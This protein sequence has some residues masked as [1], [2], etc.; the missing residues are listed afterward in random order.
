MFATPEYAGELDSVQ[1]AARNHENCVHLYIY[2]N[3]CLVLAY[4]VAGWVR[5]RPTIADMA[6]A[7]K[8]SSFLIKCR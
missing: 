7:V 8:G 1:I 2:G 3:D 6:K 5:P 4:P